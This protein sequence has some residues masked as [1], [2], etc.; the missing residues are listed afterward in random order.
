MSTASEILICPLHSSDEAHACARLMADSEPWMTLRRSFDG[1]LRLLSDPA[2]EVHVAYSGS[3]LVGFVVLHL[4]G[5][6]NGYLQ[7]I[8]VMP[9]WRGLGIGEKL[10][11]FTEQRIFRESPNV[12]LCVSSFNAG[13]RKLYARLGYEHVGEFKNYILNGHS[14]FLMRKTL[15]PWA[16]F[17]PRT[18]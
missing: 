3:T 1:C 16:D 2:K 8:A 6:F 15:G 12:F 11:H 5:P 17:T 18:G 7:A 4:G 14:E 10:I 13:A 9:Q